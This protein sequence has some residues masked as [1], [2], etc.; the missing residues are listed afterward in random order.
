MQQRAN[1]LQFINFK[2]EQQQKN[3]RSVHSRSEHL[4]YKQ[5]I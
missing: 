4:G 1:E 5:K 2:S 3:H